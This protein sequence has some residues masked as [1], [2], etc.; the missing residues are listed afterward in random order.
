MAKLLDNEYSMVSFK[1]C[2]E[3]KEDKKNTIITV[4]LNFLLFRG[5]G[6]SGTKEF[7]FTLTNNHLYIDD[8][9]YD[10]TGQLEI[11]VTEKIDRKDINSFEVRKEGNK[12]IITLSKSKGKPITYISDNKNLLDLATE[13][14]KLIMGNAGN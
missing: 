13:V 14:A 6:G 7:I 4:L 10:M 9:G 5:V 1:A 11:F 12:E 3:S 2:K 8:I